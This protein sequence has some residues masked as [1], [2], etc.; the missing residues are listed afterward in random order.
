VVFLV[1]AAAVELQV[2][3]MCQRTGGCVCFLLVFTI[4]LA[5]STV[6]WHLINLPDEHVPYYFYSRPKLKK[7]C[8]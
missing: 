6:P 5:D 3:G 1:S 4:L 8:H 7:I 2:L